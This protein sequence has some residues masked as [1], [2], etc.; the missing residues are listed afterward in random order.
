MGTF[1]YYRQLNENLFVGFDT[2]L[3]HESLTDNYYYNFNLAAGLK[4]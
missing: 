1:S 3:T 2:M 4:L